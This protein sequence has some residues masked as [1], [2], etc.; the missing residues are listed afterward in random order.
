LVLPGYRVGSKS[1]SVS[2]KET[3]GE[4]K[5]Q[6]GR[7][8]DASRSQGMPRMARHQKLRENCGRDSYSEL[9]VEINPIDTLISGFW[10]LLL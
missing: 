3:A 8:C 5:A 4:T 1:N 6:K 9:P 10:P 2:L 7:P